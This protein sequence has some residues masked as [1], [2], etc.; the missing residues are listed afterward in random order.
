[1]YFFSMIPL[2]IAHYTE[3][4]NPVKSRFAK[5]ALIRIEKYEDDRRVSF[6]YRGR[7]ENNMR[8]SL[9]AESDTG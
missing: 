3:D 8:V 2:M 6:S 4:F 7:L 9:C 5:E 1:M